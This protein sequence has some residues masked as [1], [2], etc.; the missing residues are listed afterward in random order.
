L[1]CRIVQKLR[2]RGH[3]AWLV[4]GCVRDHLLGRT[5]ADF[6]VATSALP[7]Q[8]LE[9]YPRALQV[10]RAFGVI[11]VVENGVSVEVATFRIEGNYSD[12]RRPDHVEFTSA[13]EDA[14]RR[15]FTINALFMDPVSEEV[16]DH[17]GGV[18]DI[19]RSVIRAVGDPFQRFSED[20]LRVLRA[21]RFASDLSATLDP[22]TENALRQM[23]PSLSRVSP[24]R[25]FDELT[26][27]LTRQH[28][29]R[30]LQLMESCG[31]LPHILPELI[32]MVGCTQPPDHHP[33]GDVFVH[34]CL[35]LD[36]LPS[37]PSEALAWAALLHDVGKP[38]TRTVA[39]DGR[40]RF[41]GHASV[42]T[43]MIPALAE[44]LRWPNH[45]RQAVMAMV[46]HHMDWLNIRQMKKSTLR[47]WFAQPTIEDEFHLHQ[48]DCLGSSGHLDSHHYGQ[49]VLLNIRNEQGGTTDLPKPFVSGNDLI[50]LGIP[51]GPRFKV[52]L[53]KIRDAQLDG[54][55][56]DRESS[57][58]LLQHIARE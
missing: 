31:L 45:L 20:S 12:G 17:V 6:D 36:H 2:S 35:V 1:A 10:G 24:E 40:I 38:S 13:Q 18:S 11:V 22:A 16:V 52:L 47:R 9:L 14:F 33:E 54:R 48:A 50:S 23:A 56:T 28:P 55:V 7:E 41:N 42:G 4:G 30:F 51:P 34:T 53:E 57:L 8:T 27:G 43:D 29:G 32:P 3:E 58:S 5:P 15:D 46:H 26:K 44:R 19:K 25:I 49:E 21:I 37:E 39:P